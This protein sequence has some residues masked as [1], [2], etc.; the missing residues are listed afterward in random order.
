M[1]HTYHT[2]KTLYDERYKSNHGQMQIDFQTFIILFLCSYDEYVSCILATGVF[3][4][5]KWF[6]I[7]DFFIFSNVIII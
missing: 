6:H 2:L 5:D 7:L 1:R 4:F 3:I